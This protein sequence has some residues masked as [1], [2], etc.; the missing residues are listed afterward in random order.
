[1]RRVRVG[2]RVRII[3]DGTSTLL[4]PDTGYHEKLLLEDTGRSGTVVG[5]SKSDKRIA[6][7]EWDAGS[8]RVFDDFSLGPSGRLEVR[9]RGRVHMGPIESEIHS[10]FIEVIGPATRERTKPSKSDRTTTAATSSEAEGGRGPSTLTRL[11]RM[12]IGL[13]TEEKKDCY[14]EMRRFCD[15]SVPATSGVDARIRAVLRAGEKWGIS[16]KR[17][18]RIF[19][20]GLQNGWT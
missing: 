7:V 1:M 6:R 14:R 12:F 11:R 8:Y 4:P 13:S 16:V 5:F 20:E 9:D 18:N 10:D 3:K 19:A 15:A 2:D 17:A